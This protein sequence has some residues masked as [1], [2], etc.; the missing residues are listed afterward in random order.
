MA[1]FKAPF[2]VLVTLFFFVGFGYGEASD[3]CDRYDQKIDGPQ[4]RYSMYAV[5][6]GFAAFT[7]IGCSIDWRNRV[8]CAMELLAFDATAVV[9]DFITGQEVGMTE[10]YFVIFEP[11]PESKAI[12]A[13][14]DQQ[15]AV[16]HA[17]GHEGGKVV[18]F[19]GLTAIIP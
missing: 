7:D 19:T 10:S 1:S 5:V 8:L 14:A 11:S 16:L 13:F 15:Q 17:A 9:F 2:F 4:K 18:D 3:K 6:N 12:V